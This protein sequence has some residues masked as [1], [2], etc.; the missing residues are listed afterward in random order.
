MVKD[1]DINTTSAKNYSGAT[2]VR[3][4]IDNVAQ[5]SNSWGAPIVK[6]KVPFKYPKALETIKGMGF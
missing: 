1:F 3:S 6:K 2:N 5:N 4:A